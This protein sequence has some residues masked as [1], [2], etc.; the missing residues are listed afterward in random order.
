MQHC[1]GRRLA[2]RAR[3]THRGMY[4]T[5]PALLAYLSCHVR[6]ACFCISLKSYAGLALSPHQLP[7]HWKPLGELQ[8]VQGL[9]QSIH[10]IT[11]VCYTG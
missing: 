4:V 9:R 10:T 2:K 5:L 6:H 1:S 8:R 7:S 3:Y 11:Y